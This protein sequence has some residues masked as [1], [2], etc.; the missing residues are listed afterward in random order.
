[1]ISYLKTNQNHIKEI[2]SIQKHLSDLNESTFDATIDI[3]KSSKLYQDREG[4]KILIKNIN[5]FFKFRRKQILSFFKLIDVLIP[6]VKEN[7]NKREIMTL[8]KRKE[9]HLKLFKDGLIS[10][11]DIVTFYGIKNLNLAFFYPEIQCLSS[12][13]PTFMKELKQAP[14]YLSIIEYFTNDSI[15]DDPRLQSGNT[16]ILSVSIQNDDIEKFQS[17]LSKNNINIQNH[18]IRLTYSELNKYLKKRDIYL[19]EYAA[20][21]CSFKIFKFLLM[22]EASFST[23]FLKYAIC[24]GDN[25]IIHLAEKAIAHSDVQQDMNE[26]LS[27][28]IIFHRYELS[29]YLIEFHDVKIENKDFLTSIF[30]SNY[31]FFENHILEISEEYN[32]LLQIK[33]NSYL[34]DTDIYRLNELKSRIN[35]QVLLSAGNSDIFFLKFLI[36][37]DEIDF[38]LT[39]ASNSND[40]TSMINPLVYAIQTRNNENAKYLLSLKQ[41]QP[42]WNLFYKTTPFLLSCYVGNLEMVEYFINNYYLNTEKG[43]VDIFQIVE[44]SGEN[45]LH[46]ATR[47]SHFDV[48]KYLVSLNVFDLNAKSSQDETPLQVAA[49]LGYKDIF[50]FLKSTMMNNGLTVDESL[51]CNEQ[52]YFPLLNLKPFVMGFTLFE[53]LKEPISLCLLL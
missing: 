53:N 39:G 33:E 23:L 13:Y 25:E 49:R 45:A 40:N 8:F 21:H 14:K 44:K 31:L 16:D 43:S 19:I 38:N 10:I 22:N 26:I 2:T 35:E 24:G 32:Y 1:M 12:Q 4:M 17:I 34:S 37:F 11:E 20:F 48:V 52:R 28:S 18:K 27:L 7:F 36:N 46:L 3:I 6:V 9:I 29:E 30:Y 47:Q 50:D 15:G 51:K 42:D 5:I 41:I